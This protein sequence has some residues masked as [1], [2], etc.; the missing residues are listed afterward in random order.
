M[1]LISEINEFIDKTKNLKVAV[2][3]E[4]IIDEFVHVNYEGRSMKSNCSVLRR[5]SKIQKQYGGAAVIAKHLEEF[6]DSV[7]LISNS[8]EEIVKTRYIDSFSGEKYVEINKFDTGFFGKISVDTNDYDIV[9]VADFGHGFC[10]Q[11]DINDG[12]HLMCQ[13]NSNNYGFNRVSKWRQ[14]RKKSIT[15]DKREGSL[16]INKRADFKT[17][18]EILELHNYEANT[19]DLFL[20]LG[21]VGSVFTNGSIVC[22]QGGFSTMVVDTI[23]AGDTFFAFSSVAS[24]IGLK[25]ENKMLIPSLAA[26]LSTTWLCNEKNVSPKRLLSF[27]KNYSKG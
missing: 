27:A 17:D 25:N 19:D 7:T 15:I 10:D 5:E 23:G 2:I 26:A 14:H 20:T 8:K 12:F 4:T 1:K 24:A 6:V 21:S 9:I 3:G 16:Q 13:T 11:L 22:R 18:E